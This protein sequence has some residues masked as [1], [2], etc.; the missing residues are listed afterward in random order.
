[1][2]RSAAMASVYLSRCPYNSFL[3]CLQYFSHATPPLCI[4][5]PL[6]S[7]N[8]QYGK[9]R[10]EEPKTPLA[11]LSPIGSS[12]TMLL[13]P[14]PIPPQGGKLAALAQA[15]SRS[16]CSR[17]WSQEGGRHDL[18]GRD[19]PSRQPTPYLRH[20]CIGLPTTEALCT[21]L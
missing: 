13:P 12:E 8:R 1:M 16:R 5:H 9:P 21:A 11:K 3:F 4:F 6:S 7:R 10:D 14:S 20:Q 19:L 18:L 15:T 2:R 17:D